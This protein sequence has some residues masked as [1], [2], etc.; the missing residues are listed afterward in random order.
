[1][2][3]LIGLL[4]LISLVNGHG[5]MVSPQTRPS[6][7]F[8]GN[9]RAQ[10]IFWPPDGSGIT[11]PACR[12][13][14]LDSVNRNVEPTA[15]FIS[16]MSY[17]GRNRNG[18]R[19]GFEDG[20]LMSL[21]EVCSAG[22][23]VGYRVNGDFRSQDRILPWMKE[24]Y[25]LVNGNPRKE[26]TFRFCAT[27]PHHRHVWYIYHHAHDPHTSALRWDRLNFIQEISVAQLQRSN[28]P[29]ENCFVHDDPSHNYYEFSVTIPLVRDGTI[30]TIMQTDHFY[31]WEFILGCHDYTTRGGA[32]LPL[33]P[34]PPPPQNGCPRP[35]ECRVNQSFWAPYTDPRRFYGCHE[36]V[37]S[38][39]GCGNNQVFTTS[40][41]C[42]PLP[43]PDSERFECQDWSNIRSVHEEF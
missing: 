36:G 40:R 32:P 11:D 28:L 14:F 24:E 12:G 17:V 42:R 30:V 10:G 1:M 16:R 3:T 34:P 15:Q 19:F 38:V 21:N 26:I 7:C 31:N 29:I 37:I 9:S 13:A 22:S 8:H 18:T 43:I 2:Y 35:T 4:A 23:Q 27:A 41:Q 6:R 33:P 20:S 25:T 5:Y 39:H